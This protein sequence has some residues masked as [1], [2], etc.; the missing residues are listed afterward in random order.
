MDLH[1]VG[2]HCILTSDKYRDKFN[3]D[4]PLLNCNKEKQ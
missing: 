2:F 1:S 4:D 3:I